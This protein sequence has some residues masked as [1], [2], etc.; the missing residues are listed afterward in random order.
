MGEGFL[1]KMS[2]FSWFTCVEEAEFF[3]EA[4]MDFFFSL[5]LFFL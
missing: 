1:G 4:R 3:V 5:I 2:G